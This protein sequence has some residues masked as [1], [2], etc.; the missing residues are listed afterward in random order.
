MT[1]K[2]RR[3]S[4]KGQ[5]EKKVFN[6]RSAQDVA[7]LVKYVPILYFKSHIVRNWE[8]YVHPRAREYFTSHEGLVEALTS[9]ARNINQSDDPIL[10]CL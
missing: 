4:K 1:S 10:V 2:C 9:I 3:R 7:E 6:P 8:G 5:G